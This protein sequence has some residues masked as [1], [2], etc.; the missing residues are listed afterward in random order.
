MDTCDVYVTCHIYIKSIGI[1]LEV[2]V[3]QKVQVCPQYFIFNNLTKLNISCKVEY[4]YSGKWWSYN[5]TMNGMIGSEWV[6][7]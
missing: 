1:P 5:K 6:E 7:L 3:F 4:F 2:Y